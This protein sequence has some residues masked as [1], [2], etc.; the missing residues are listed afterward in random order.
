MTN[1]SS[2]KEETP[3]INT[4]KTVGISK[5]K[6][7]ERNHSSRH[8]ASDMVKK[9]KGHNTSCKA[10]ART[11]CNCSKKSHLVQYLKSEDIGQQVQ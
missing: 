11:C 10:K 5:R 4:T 3:P 2:E 8:I 7:S 1:G 9:K 6:Q